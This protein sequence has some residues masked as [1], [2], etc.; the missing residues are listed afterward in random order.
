M[1]IGFA[2][3]WLN[4]VPVVN[5]FGN[6]HLFTSFP[7][8]L[9]LGEGGDRNRSQY[10]QT[11]LVLSTRFDYNNHEVECQL[12]LFRQTWSRESAFTRSRWA[13]IA[14]PR[15]WPCAPASRALRRLIQRGAMRVSS[16]GRSRLTRPRCL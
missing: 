16:P 1:T 8:P 2:P 5:E 12:K 14:R 15:S 9:T 6:G 7:L 10:G 3:H 11:K 13:L 4:V